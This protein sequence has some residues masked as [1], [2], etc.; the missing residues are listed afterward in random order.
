MIFREVYAI[1]VTIVMSNTLL[2]H[3]HFISEMN[4]W[5]IPILCNQSEPNQT[6]QTLHPGLIVWQSSHQPN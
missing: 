5:L 6:T 2:P 3:T 4:E 1:I